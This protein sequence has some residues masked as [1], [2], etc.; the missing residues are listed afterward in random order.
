MALTN[1]E[2]KTLLG[3]GE[4][5]DDTV[6]K[7]KIMLENVIASK[8]EAL[9]E[10]L[11]KT[12][13]DAEAY[14]AHVKEELEAQAEAYGEYVKEEM[15]SQAEAYAEYVKEETDS[16]VEAY[17]EYVVKEFVSENKEALVE[18][19][20]YARMKRAFD[21]IKNVFESEFFRVEPVEGEVDTLKL[22][23]SESAKSYESLFENYR[24]ILKE[25][26]EMR[27]AIIFE[28][29]TQGLADTQKER[30]KTLVENVSFDN[31]T[32]FQRGVELMV[33]EVR[34]EKNAPQQEQVEEVKTQE[35]E[36]YFDM[37][38]YM[39]HMK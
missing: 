33:E 37:S 6:T 13:S 21:N 24:S 4:V 31:I 34:T 27:T 22:E 25:N 8:T 19:V 10:E 35:K 11:E 26:E 39:K 23:I 38:K 32:E 3:E 9:T 18:G 29:V 36:T 2:I 20:E 12:K 14:V 1:E 28:H 15:E 16:Q 17:A 7:L 5:S 30:V